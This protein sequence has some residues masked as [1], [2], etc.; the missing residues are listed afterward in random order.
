MFKVIKFLALCEIWSSETCFLTA[1]KMSAA[2]I[3]HLITKVYGA[4]T[5]TE[6]KVRLHVRE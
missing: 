3:P 4:K 1:T 6:D 2:D 5:M